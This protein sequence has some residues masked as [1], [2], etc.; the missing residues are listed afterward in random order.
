MTIRSSS[1]SGIPFGDTS[2]RPSSPLTGQP[3]FNGELQ[4][5]EL[6]TGASYGWQ[7]IVAETPGVTGYSGTVLDTNTMNTITIT[8]TNFAS[9]A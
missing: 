9:G 3:Y 1:S 6:Y 7:N 5:L 4:R 2:S 8:G